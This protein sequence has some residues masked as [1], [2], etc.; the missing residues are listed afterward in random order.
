MHKVRTARGDI[1]DFDEVR[2]KQSLAQSPANIQVKAREQFIDQRLKRTSKRRAALLSQQLL[3]QNQETLEPVE[4][5]PL[6]DDEAEAPTESVVEVVSEDVKP[7]TKINRRP[8]PTQDD[9]EV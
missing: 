9:V 7:R 5:L 4:E 8:T 1:I 6:V 3:D 2:V